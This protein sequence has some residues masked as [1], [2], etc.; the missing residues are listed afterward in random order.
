MTISATNA[1]NDKISASALFNIN[2]AAAASKT[3]ETEALSDRFL[4]LL[5]AQLKNQDPMNPMENAELT[6]Q[7]AQMSTVEGVSK[8]NTSMEGLVSQFKASQ[9]MQGAAL[10]GR[11]VMTEGDSLKLTDLGAAG[12]IDLA[13]AAENV[14]VS[15]SDSYGNLVH[16]LDLGRQPAG[17]MNFV[18]D[19]KNATGEMQV[20]GDYRFKVGASAAEQ[21]VVA[22]G[23]ALG[24][25]SSV[26]L[27]GNE[28]GVEVAGLGVRRLDQIRQIF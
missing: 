8:L 7:L 13:A 24:N 18:W 11:Q 22:T 20:G 27:N 19:G 26:A 9:V 23:Y 5:V 16:T 4:K 15:I 2:G 25:V 3:S 28:M 1:V 17:L 6:S 21:D 12:G 10:V 14:K